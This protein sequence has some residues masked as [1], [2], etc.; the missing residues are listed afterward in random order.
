MHQLFTKALWKLLLSAL[1]KQT[2]AANSFNDDIYA[3]S[4]SQRPLDRTA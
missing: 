2:T 1:E 4:S 3:E